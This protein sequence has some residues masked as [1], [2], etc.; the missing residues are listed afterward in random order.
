MRHLPPLQQRIDRYMHQPGPHGGKRHQA[1]QPMFAKPGGDPVPRLQSLFGQ[2]L[3]H[4]PH[5]LVQLGKA[6]RLGLQQQ[7][8][9]GRITHQSQMV[10]GVD[11]FA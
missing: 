10:D 5:A 6:Q 4:A 3:R 1:G 8:G 9:C 11:T 7:R 2:Q